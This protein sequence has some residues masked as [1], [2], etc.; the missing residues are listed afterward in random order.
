VPKT[1]ADDEPKDRSQRAVQSVE[2]GGR[3]LLALADRPGAMT[4]KDLAAQADLPPSRAHPYLVS[5]GKL[6]L[7]EQD[8]A[9]GRYALGPA[10][11][12]LG[13]ACLNQLDPIKVAVP[14]AQDLANRSGHAVAL[15]LWGNFGPTVVRLFE[16]RQPLHVA[17]RA[18][19]VMSLLGT[20]TGQAFAAVL[21]VHRVQAV[22]TAA[23]REG[24]VERTA[25]APADL[26]ELARVTADYRQ[27]G[28]A[29]AA[30]RPIPG[31]NAFSAAAFDH[32]GQ[33]A[34]VITALD[35]QDH[36]AADW[37]SPAALA[38]RDAAHEV[39]RRL[40]WDGPRPGDLRPAGR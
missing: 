24:D 28:V 31:V 18:G 29:R 7:I 13:L 17:M 1:A 21:P 11:L 5:F 19:T 9:S 8:P 27:H 25:A 23:R 36:L 6:G 38:V 4:L 37:S 35:H 34:L 30:G 14:L 15:A 12:Q 2:V 3:L 39:S 33:P 10:A 22:L 26:D 20:A 32:E 40:G 16:A